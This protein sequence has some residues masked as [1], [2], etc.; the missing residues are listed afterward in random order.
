MITSTS[1][2]IL[3][4][5]DSEFFRKKLGRILDEAGHS[6][7]FASDGAEVKQRLQKTPAEIDLLVLD[8]HMPGLDGFGV[9]EWM[10][11]EGFTGRL[12]VLV[13][14]GEY[15]PEEVVERIN[16]RV[17]SGIMTKDFSPEQVVFQINKLLFPQKSEDRVDPRVP[18]SAPVEYVVGDTIE[19]GFLLNISAK[20]MFLH[21]RTEL[22][23]GLNVGLKFSLPDSTRV[24][25]VKGVVMWS[26]PS[27]DHK[28]LFGG[29]GIMFAT[30]SEEDRREIKRFVATASQKLTF[31]A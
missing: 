14:T 8:L 20:G 28:S 3:L 13:V 17:T 1:K 18:V 4:V 31:D 24:Y 22:I 19:R 26:T 9:L 29:A 15:K 10:A 6:V 25:E 30:L 23:P 7:S 2:N 12:P 21:T 5:D 27:S 16:P 11:N